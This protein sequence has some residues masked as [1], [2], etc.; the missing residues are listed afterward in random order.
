MCS[1]DLLGGRP[2]AL[3][4]ELTGTG[5]QIGDLDAAILQELLERGRD[6]LADRIAARL[7]AAGRTLL[8]DGRP[9]ERA[10]DRRRMV[11]AACDAFLTTSLPQIIRLGI[12]SA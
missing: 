2:I 12:A 5:H 8:E 3:A 9:V 10:E 6:G 4:S 7:E 1:S 11:A